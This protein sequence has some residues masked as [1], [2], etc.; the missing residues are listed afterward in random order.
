MK[1]MSAPRA[2][3]VAIATIVVG[4]ATFIVTVNPFPGASGPASATTSV[5]HGSSVGAPVARQSGGLIASGPSRSECLTPHA[6]TGTYGLAYLSSLVT[7]FDNETHSS[8]TC[9]STFLS[10]AP[11]WSAWERPWVEDPTYGYGP[12]VAQA[13]QSRQL[14]LEVDLIPDSLENVNNPL[15]WEES[16]AAGAFNAHASALGASLVAAGLQNSVL[17]LG[18]EM[19]GIWEADFI[20]TTNVEQKLWATCFANEVTALR[21]TPGEHFLIDWNVNACKGDYSYA[22]FYPG[23]A[24]VDILGLDL[25]DVACEIPNT[26]VTFRQLSDEQ[27]GLKYFESFASAHG[28]PMSFP[29]WGLSTIPAGD[30]PAYV[31]GIGATV[32]RGNFSFETYFDAGGL[33]KNL[34]LTGKTPK[35]L[36]AFRKWFGAKG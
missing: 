18:A 2:R 17:R 21:Q 6:A 5:A 36:V 33:G 23:N 22:N 19:N 7:S 1:K 25:Y 12:W 28:K 14:V 35:S 27:L 30:D 34:P 9:L 10:G 32:T 8:V 11:N 4:V 16:C 13:P 20:G 24:Y 29:E 3:A 26:K 31:N 15:G